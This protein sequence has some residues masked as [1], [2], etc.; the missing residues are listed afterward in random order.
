ML[1]LVAC[2]PALL[3]VAF[4]IP[5]LFMV[6]A[7]Q[8]SDTAVRHGNYQRLGLT[9]LELL[10]YNSKESSGC[11]ATGWGNL[12]RVAQQGTGKIHLVSNRRG[13]WANGTGTLSSRFLGVQGL[14]SV[15][16]EL[17]M[18]WV[19][20]WRILPFVLPFTS[21]FFEAMGLA[22]LTTLIQH[23]KVEPHPKLAGEPFERLKEIYSEAKWALSLK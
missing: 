4:K 12:H 15:V 16:G 5:I 14:A 20:D 11:T 8:V 3:T 9:T 13:S 2:I 21:R 19:P 7:C 23:Y 10:H 6:V 22:A 17:F 18:F 1:I